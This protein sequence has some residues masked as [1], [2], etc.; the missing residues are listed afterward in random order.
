MSGI[1]FVHTDHF[2]L[3]SPV[4][5]LAFAPEWLRQQARD[6][7]REAVQKVVSVA[8][9]RNTQFLYVAGR[10]T[11]SPEYLPNVVRWLKGP[12]GQLRSRGTA[13]VMTARDAAESTALSEICDVVIESGQRLDVD[14]QG[15]QL[16]LL[17]VPADS[18]TDAE[19]VISSSGISSFDRSSRN[20]CHYLVAP[21]Q[22]R[23]ASSSHDLRAA[24]APQALHP[25]E[26]GEHGCLVVEAHPET[27]A[28]DST[29]EATDVLR[30]EKRTL[31]EATLEHE[32][33]VSEAIINASRHLARQE[34]RT[35][36]VDWKIDH[37]V[38]RRTGLT[39]LRENQ[40]LKSTWRMM[41]EGHVGIWPRRIEFCPTTV[42]VTDRSASASIT[43]L[44]SVLFPPQSVTR[45]E[46]A[47]AEFALATHFL[48]RAA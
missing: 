2:R 42:H 7:V 12:F 37:P 3:G 39:S 43:E 40:L 47:L 9:A 44:T 19:L 36:I 25:S 11:D 33:G 21:D 6:A 23:T 24:G 38:D 16:E 22:S 15:S 1:R 4:R 45:R 17:S 18:P 14:R 35:V 27:G 41:Q 28:I 30:F 10:C 5:G 26:T 48:G 20:R 34:A 8:A 32:R 29:F 13:I 31:T 46:T